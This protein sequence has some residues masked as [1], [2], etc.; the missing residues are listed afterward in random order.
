MIK[1]VIGLKTRIHKNRVTSHKASSMSLVKNIVSAYDIHL[2]DTLLTEQL[3]FGILSHRST[4]FTSHHITS[5]V[6]YE[7]QG[8]D[9]IS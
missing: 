5:C 7:T 9:N 1:I 3:S 8:R 2:F 4:L 6:P